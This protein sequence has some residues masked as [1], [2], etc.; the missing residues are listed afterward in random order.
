MQGTGTE[1]RQSRVKKRAAESDSLTTKSRNTL[2]WD[3]GIEYF[4]PVMMPIHW[5]EFY[6]DLRKCQEEKDL[7]KQGVDKCHDFY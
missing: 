1:E 4:S 3:M 6:A 7:F 5:A 2:P